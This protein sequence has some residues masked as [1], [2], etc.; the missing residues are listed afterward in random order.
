MLSVGAIRFEDVVGVLGKE[1][2]FESFV[3]FFDSIRWLLSSVVVYGCE[4][5]MTHC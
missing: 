5:V 2:N 1:E 4:G 3:A